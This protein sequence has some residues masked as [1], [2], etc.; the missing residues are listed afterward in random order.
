VA[1]EKTLGLVIRTVDFS[2]SSS[3]VTLFTRDFGK[4]AALAKGA[5]RLRSQFLCALDLLCL[6]RI[7]L[8][9]KRAETLD[10]LTEAQLEKGFAA[11]RDRFD[12]LVAGCA[13]AE[14]L[15]VLTEANDPHPRLFDESI[16]ALRALEQGSRL[17]LVLR[18]FELTILRR[19][20]YA[21]RLDSCG[22]CSRPFRKGSEAAAFDPFCGGLVCT[23][24]ES[25]V[26]EPVRLQQGTVKVLSLL[27]EPG[28]RHWERLRVSEPMMSQ[29]RA[30]TQAA[31]SRLAGRRLKT[32]RFLEE[33]GL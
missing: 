19:I 12:V 2:E 10:L 23:D 16:Q 8:I 20:G 11:G 4:V 18:R 14:L 5:K 22:L 32:W 24:C 25:R 7:V 1:T 6:S 33:L 27:A 30:V 26:K 15:S 13:L 9:R 17:G 28:S 31:I 3:V 29:V 21:L